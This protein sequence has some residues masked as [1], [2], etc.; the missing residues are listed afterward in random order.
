MVGEAIQ[1]DNE[2]QGPSAPQLRTHETR[3]ADFS[4]IDLVVVDDE[5]LFLGMGKKLGEIK[6][7][8]SIQTFQNGREFVDNLAGIPH[9]SIVISDFNMPL[10][11]GLAAAREVKK[12]RPDIKIIIA[13]GGKFEKWEMDAALADGTIQAFINKPYNMEE[14]ATTVIRLK[15]S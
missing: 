8:K 11:N 10:L 7:A 12:T 1:P 13:S 15:N 6:K 2:Q 4:D 14:M 5:P 9:G 3:E